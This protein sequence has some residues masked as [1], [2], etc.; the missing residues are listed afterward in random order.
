MVTGLESPTHLLIILI[1]VLLF[2]GGKR[3]LELAKGHEGG[4][5]AHNEEERKREMGTDEPGSRQGPST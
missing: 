5:G 3:I 2:V 1:V 4:D